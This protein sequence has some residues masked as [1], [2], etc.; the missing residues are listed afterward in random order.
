MKQTLGLSYGILCTVTQ[1]SRFEMPD[2]LAL[3]QASQQA[4]G[5]KA[6]PEKNVTKKYGKPKLHLV[7]HCEQ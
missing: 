1:E 3:M 4:L 6:K 5:V 2:E 7:R